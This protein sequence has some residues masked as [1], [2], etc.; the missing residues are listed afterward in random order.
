MSD[1]YVSGIV[2]KYLLTQA[3]K[4][5]TFQNIAPLLTTITSWGG[6]SLLTYKASGSFAKDTAIRGVT[7]IDIFL[8][9]SPQLSW[10]LGTLYNNLYSHLSINNY[11]VRKQNV[12]IGVK[13]NQVSIDVI[14]AKKQ[15]GNTNDHSLYTNKNNSWIQTNVDQHINIVTQSGRLNEIRAIKIWAA[16]HQLDFPSFY[17]ELTVIAALR[18]Q[19]QNQLFSNFVTTLTYIRDNLV[20]ATIQDPS[21]SANYVSN[22]LNQTEKNTIVNAARLSLTRSLTNVIW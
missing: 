11:Q 21:N 10:N 8:S 2:S 9:F 22:S 17:L 3:E 20:D 5:L 12:S 16:L 14:P 13:Y 15:L 6:S 4:N 7:D 19:R 18:N 1:I